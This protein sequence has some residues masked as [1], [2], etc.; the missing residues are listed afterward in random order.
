MASI[1][2][3]VAYEEKVVALLKASKFLPAC[4]VVDDEGVRQVVQA[5]DWVV[6][7]G[8]E[9]DVPAE[10]VAHQLERSMSDLQAVI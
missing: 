4:G 10:T 8:Y 3:Y 6:A 9:D 5:H 2:D 1:S 7:D